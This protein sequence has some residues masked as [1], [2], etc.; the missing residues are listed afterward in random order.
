MSFH[1]LIRRHLAESWQHKPLRRIILRAS[2]LRGQCR[3]VA[4]YY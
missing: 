4:E 2:Q 3:T 1:Q